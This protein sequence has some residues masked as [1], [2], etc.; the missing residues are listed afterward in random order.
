MRTKN[1]SFCEKSKK[2]RGGLFS[3]GGGGGV[4]VDVNKELLF[5]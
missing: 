1:L 4:K 5:L 2:I 3:G